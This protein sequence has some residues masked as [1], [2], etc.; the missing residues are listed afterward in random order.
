MASHSDLPSTIA[1]H[2][3]EFV[4]LARVYELV[5]T[6]W[7]GGRS[8]ATFRT[9]TVL[10]MCNAVLIATLFLYMASSYNETPRIHIV[11]VWSKEYILANELAKK[12]H[13]RAAP[14]GVGFASQIM[15]NPDQYAIEKPNSLPP[16]YVYRT[17]DNFTKANISNKFIPNILAKDDFRNKTLSRIRDGGTLPPNTTQKLNLEKID[18]LISSLVRR[19]TLKKAK[20]ESNSSEDFQVDGYFKVDSEKP[21]TLRCSTCALVT[22]SGRLINRSAGVDIDSAKCVIRMNDAPTRG[23]ENDVGK[24][25]T[26]RVIGHVNMEKMNQTERV[27][28]I[29]VDG[30][31]RTNM[32]IIPWLYNDTINRTDNYYELVRNFS[33][34]FPDVEFFVIS[35]RMIESVENIFT[36]EVGFTRKDAKT[37]FTTG[38]MSMLFAID[39]CDRIDVYGMLSHRYCIE[40][41]DNSTMYH[42]YEPNGT[43]ECSYYSWSEHNL[44]SGHLFMTEKAVFARWAQKFDIHFHHPEWNITALANF[45]KT[46]I[47]TPFVRAFRKQ[48][49][50]KTRV[51]RRKARKKPTRGCRTVKC[52]VILSLMPVLALYVFSFAIWI[53]IRKSD[54]D[55]DALLLNH[56]KRGFYDDETSSSEG[57]DD[58]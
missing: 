57:D 7:P 12:E 40:N 26:I 42:Y 28:E 55:S 29:F 49:K 44:K 14:S 4:D 46:G 36:E 6:K 37:W 5:R 15:Q 25:T 56:Q 9:F 13:K 53:A 3:D 10:V 31:T 16:N 20:L 17:L 45:T 2:A 22:S 54:P 50:R 43:K 52:A 18:N 58:F 39:A 47:D 8:C 38:W 33:L 23:F 21:L 24:R 32:A 11:Q 1:S 27:D 35:P 19:M 34:R 41:T 30:K 51:M 48:K